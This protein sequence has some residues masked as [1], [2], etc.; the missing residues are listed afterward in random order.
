MVGGFDE[1]M[2]TREDWDFH[3][4][5]AMEGLCGIRV[6]QPL[7]SY[8]HAT[9]QRRVEQATDMARMLRTKYPL[10][11]LTMACPGCK[12][13]RAA[14]QPPQTWS[15]KEEAGFVQLEYV[16]KNRAT[17]T[18]IGITGRPYRFGN[19]DEA[20]LDWVHPT[21]ADDFINVKHLPFKQIPVLSRTERIPTAIVAPTA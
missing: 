17:G 15:T 16:G 2:H 6:P 14:I 5:L 1:E 18:F 13:K 20:R 12:K 21:D 10:E 4:K 7:L 3:F 11:E 8:R 9:G 19:N